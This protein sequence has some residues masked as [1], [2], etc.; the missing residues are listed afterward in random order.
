MS[1]NAS[2]NIFGEGLDHFSRAFDLRQVLP[3]PAL[4]L[5][6]RQNKGKAQTGTLHRVTDR[7]SPGLQ[8][9][10]KIHEAGRN[11]SSMKVCPVLGNGT[12]LTT[13]QLNRSGLQD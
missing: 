11:C 5:G 10:T 13:S 2:Q 9:Y 12:E 7:L 4:A 8:S 1:V 3:R 6:N